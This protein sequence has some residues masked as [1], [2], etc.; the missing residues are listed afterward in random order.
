[1]NDAILAAERAIRE[2]IQNNRIVVIDAS[3]SEGLRSNLFACLRADCDNWADREDMRAGGD[4]ADRVTE[5]WGS[6]DDGEDWRIH[7]VYRA[8]QS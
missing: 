5:F 8:V 1:M 7:V 2:S 6:T 4:D 3:H